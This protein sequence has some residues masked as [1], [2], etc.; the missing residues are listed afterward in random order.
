MSTRIDTLRKEIESLESRA[1]F[2]A[3]WAQHLEE[4]GKS[5]EDKDKLYTIQREIEGINHLV[6]NKHKEI[7]VIEKL[8]EESELVKKELPSLIDELSSIKIT[9]KS[10]K[11]M[12]KGMKERMSGGYVS[13]SELINDYKQAQILKQAYNVLQSV[14]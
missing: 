3:D 7:K 12:L 2:L 4:N 9:D 5:F 8:S 6:T 14:K 13:H 11:A 10:H 1:E